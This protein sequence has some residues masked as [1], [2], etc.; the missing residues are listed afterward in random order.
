VA[1]PLWKDTPPHPSRGT[2]KPTPR[3]LEVLRAL[4][5]GATNQEIAEELHLSPHTVKIHVHQVLVKMGVRDRQQA[6]AYAAS[7]SIV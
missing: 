4:G 6:T 5:R 1:T 7:E 3:E 2:N